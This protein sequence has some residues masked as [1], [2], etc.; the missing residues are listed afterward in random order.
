MEP[1]SEKQ[2]MK[3]HE[4]SVN[5]DRLRTRKLTEHE[6]TV[7]EDRLRAQKM[8]NLLTK[9]GFLKVAVFGPSLDMSPRTKSG[10]L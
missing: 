5:E 8:E 2:K 3:T 10:P 9:I 7:S 6:T 1:G 4:N